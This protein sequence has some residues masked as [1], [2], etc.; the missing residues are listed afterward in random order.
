MNI[1]DVLSYDP[2]TGIIKWKIN[3]SRARAGEVAG[4]LSKN[5]YLVAGVR[6]NRGVTGKLY[7]VHR[8]AWYLHYGKWPNLFIDHINGDKTDNRIANLREVTRSQNGHNRGPNKN[9]Q[10]GYKGVSWVKATQRWTARLTVDRNV[11]VLGEF[12]DKDIAM[13]VLE[14]ARERLVGKF[15]WAA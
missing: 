11:V 12:C 10:S 9:N 5:G 6:L 15:R 2:E 3:K 14:E 4:C 1:E 13:L 7:Y 8:L